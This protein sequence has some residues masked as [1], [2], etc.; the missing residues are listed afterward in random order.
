VLLDNKNS[1][2]VGNEFKKCSFKGSRLS[3]ISSLLTIYGFSSLKKKLSKPCKEFIEMKR[4]KNKPRNT[5]NI[6]KKTFLPCFL[7]V[8]CVSGKLHD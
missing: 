7:C 6:L 3:V 8:A 1:G 2:Y 5:Q 4:V